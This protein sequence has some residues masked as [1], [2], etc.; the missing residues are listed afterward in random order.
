MG[1]S[2]NSKLSNNLHFSNNSVI[3][4]LNATFLSKITHPLYPPLYFVE[5]GKLYFVERAN[6][7]RIV[8][9]GVS[10]VY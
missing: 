8:G 3:I 5:R 7:D 9:K 2:K 4:F 1:T 6:P 10:Y